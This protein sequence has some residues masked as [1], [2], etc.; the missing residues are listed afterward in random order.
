MY[1]PPYF[2]RAM[3]T[4]AAALVAGFV[5]VPSAHAGPL[6][7]AAPSC[8]AQ[9]VDTP[10]RPWAD[11][12]SY[13]LVP[14]GTVESTRKWSLDGAAA[15]RGNERF[16]VN[17]RDDTTSLGLPPGASA[18]TAPICVGI[19]HPTLRFFARNR[20]SLLSTLRVEVLWEDAYGRVWQTPIGVVTANDGW[21]P[22]LP[23]PVVVNLLPLLPGQ[24]TA[25]AFQ[26]TVLGSGDWSIDDIYLDPW[27]H[28]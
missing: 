4:A 18:T 3:W 26:F 11:F 15:A 22:T 1:T 25:V 21:A 7:A 19:E 16:Y 17:A 23:L 27:R 14:N 20:G 28:G 12:M 24:R 10:F 13:T 6:V 2:R 8:D 9:V 5:V